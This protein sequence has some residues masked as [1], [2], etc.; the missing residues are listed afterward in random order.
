MSP[1]TSST[2]ITNEETGSEEIQEEEIPMIVPKINEEIP[3]ARLSSSELKRRDGKATSILGS[4]QL[5]GCHGDFC[6]LDLKTLETRE[7]VDRSNKLV[8]DKSITP[9]RLRLM[10]DEKSTELFSDGGS[11]TIEVNASYRIPR[12]SIIHAREEMV[13][14]EK[15]LNSLRHGQ[16]ILYDL[17]NGNSKQLNLA[18]KLPAHYYHFVP[19]CKTCYHVYTIVNDAKAKARKHIAKWKRVGADKMA[20]SPFKI[21][22]A[23]PR[24][25][26]KYTSFLITPTIKNSANLMDPA[27]ETMVKPNISLRIPSTD[28]DEPR[29]FAF[30][31]KQEEEALKPALDAIEGLTKRDVA[32]LKFLK[33]PP[34][35]VEVILEVVLLILTQKK[36]SYPEI[37]NFIGSGDSLLAMLRYYDIRSMNDEMLITIERYTNHELFSPENVVAVSRCAAKFCAWV[38]GI[39][40]AA[41]WA[42]GA[43]NDRLDEIIRSRSNSNTPKA[44]VRKNQ[45]GCSGTPMSRASQ[46]SLPSYM[47][48]TRSNSEKLF[49]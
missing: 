8:V 46:S 20:E 17:S 13:T 10:T 40:Y 30:Y 32:E 49:I 12:M 2:T 4:S 37:L 39:V 9:F 45:S 33:K 44:M 48:P 38:L 47:K 11:E 41:K 15:Y 35:A 23:K 1:K 25:E 14:I 28:S 21:E 6:T 7:M 27:T 3:N 5:V 18:V 24:R 19:I 43:G 36:L 26:N 29:K 31:Q 22:V 16:T 42:R 34:V